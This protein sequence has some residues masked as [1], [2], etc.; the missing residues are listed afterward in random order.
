MMSEKDK[1]GTNSYVGYCIDLL[2]ELPKKLRFTY[3]LY[4]SPDGLHGVETESGVWD[5]VVGELVSKV[6]K[7]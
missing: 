4:L 7:N 6:C 3:E 2:N 5:G 1:D